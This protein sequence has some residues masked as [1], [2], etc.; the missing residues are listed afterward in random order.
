MVELIVKLLLFHASGD[1][2]TI[3]ML[4]AGFGSFQAL[5]T[6]FGQRLQYLDRNFPVREDM[7]EEELQQQWD[8]YRVSYEELC[9]E[10]KQ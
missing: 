1:D 5:R 7:S 10:E 3:S 9:T 2:F 4:G 8:A 6:F